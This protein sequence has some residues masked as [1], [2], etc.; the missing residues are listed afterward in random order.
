MKVIGYDWILFLFL[1]L[2]I[3]VLSPYATY[4]AASNL[5]I[6]EIVALIIA[7]VLAYFTTGLFY[8][9]AKNRAFIYKID[10]K[11]FQT[12]ITLPYFKDKNIYIKDIEKIYFYTVRGSPLFYRHIFIRYNERLEVFTFLPKKIFKFFWNNIPR[13]YF[14][15]INYKE[16]CQLERELKNQKMQIKRY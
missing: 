15:E 12:K 2:F 7:T 4:Y 3:D 9:G 1:M 16:L 13:S 11:T 6:I 14:I 10:K 5:T 8:F